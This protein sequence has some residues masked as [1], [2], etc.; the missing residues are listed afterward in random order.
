MTYMVE[1]RNR[2]TLA[3]SDFESQMYHRALLHEGGK[4]D[5]WD[6]AP[7]LSDFNNVA[8]LAGV[9]PTLRFCVTMIAQGFAVSIL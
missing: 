4:H 8:F 2:G 6:A 1:V 5:G 3:F 7:D 9:S